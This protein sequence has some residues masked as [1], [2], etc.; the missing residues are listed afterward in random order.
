MKGDIVVSRSE[1]PAGDTPYMEFRD[2][3]FF[4]THGLTRTLPTPEEV[5]ANASGTSIPESD[6]LIPERPP[7]S[8][9]RD[10]GVLVKFGSSVTT[11]EAQCLW[12]INK[13]LKDEVYVPEVYGWRIESNEVFI[14]MQHVEGV[15]LCDRWDEF[16]DAEKNAV[17]GQLRIMMSALRRLK[18]DPND[19]FI[20]EQKSLLLYEYAKLP[21][22]CR[23]PATAIHWIP[24][25]TTTW[26][27]FQR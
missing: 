3:A 23:P 6:T 22:K 2:T 14:Y 27:I 21:R 17:C 25:T 13:H 1:L 11:A 20:G 4:R 7:P 8:I 5:R 24:P 15:D 19:V 12:L 10:L 26:S 18:Q 9:F 16:G